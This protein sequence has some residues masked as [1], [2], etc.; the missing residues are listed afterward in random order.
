M[1]LEINQNSWSKVNNK[2]LRITVAPA[3]N[4]LVSLW[5]WNLWWRR[6]GHW[7]CGSFYMHLWHSPHIPKTHLIISKHVSLVHYVPRVISE[8]RKKHETYSS[9]YFSTYLN[10]TNPQ[11]TVGSLLLM[12]VLL[13]RFSSGSVHRISYNK[14]KLLFTNLKVLRKLEKKR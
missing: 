14:K 13:P 11:F 6:K 4:L 2:L 7:M 9:S 8:I 5:L 12:L 10:Y 3:F 1:P